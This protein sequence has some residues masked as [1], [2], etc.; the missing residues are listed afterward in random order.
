LIQRLNSAL[1]AK[2]LDENV[3]FVYEDGF[4]SVVLS[5]PN[6]VVLL[7]KTLAN[8]LGFPEQALLYSFTS[9]DDECESDGP[10]PASKEDESAPQFLYKHKIESCL[11]FSDTYDSLFSQAFSVE[12]ASI[13]NVWDVSKPKI[14]LLGKSILALSFNK[15]KKKPLTTEVLPSLN[16]DCWV[17]T[18]EKDPLNPVFK[19]KMMLFHNIQPTSPKTTLT[20][21]FNPQ[22]GTASFPML[23]LYC[24]LLMPVFVSSSFA[25]LIRIIPT[26]ALNKSF[27]DEVFPSSVMSISFDPL[28]YM[29]VEVRNVEEIT[30][31]LMDEAGQLIKFSQSAR[32]ILCLH[33]R[34]RYMK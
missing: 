1:A 18:D 24:S 22:L 2:K 30:C 3:R 4:C 34:P 31:A 33:L 12:Y 19:I 26:Q 23:F 21:P 6:T 17:E 32:T 14:Q 27:D 20:A 28:L 25:R 15:K 5:Q 9:R 29:P 13:A 16:D 8:M 10:N 11:G 7:R